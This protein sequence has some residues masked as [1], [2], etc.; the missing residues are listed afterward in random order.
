MVEPGTKPRRYARHGNAGG[1]KMNIADRTRLGRYEIRQ[2]WRR[3]K[4][5]V[6]CRT[7]K[8]TATGRLRIQIDRW[9]GGDMRVNSVAVFVCALTALAGPMLQRPASSAGSQKGRAADLAAIEKLHQQE[10]AA[11]LSRDSGALTD[12]WTDD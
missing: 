3:R 1:I 5:S 11:T 7:R 6:W 2:N 8:L 10:I 9:I 12:L 4:R